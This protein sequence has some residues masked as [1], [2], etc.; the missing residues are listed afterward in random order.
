MGPLLFLIYINDLKNALDKCI[1]HYFPVDNNSLFANKSPSE[2]SCAM[3]NELKLVTLWLKTNE[4]SLIESK[5][6][7]LI[8]RLPKKLIITVPHIKLNNFILTTE[9]IVFCLGIEINE[10]LS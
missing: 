8:F 10:N 1:I 2:I 7:F 6:K 3:N 5:I 9:K 4:L